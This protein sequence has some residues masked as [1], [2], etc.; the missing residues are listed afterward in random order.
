[1]TEPGATEGAPP[2][3]PWLLYLGLSAVVWGLFVPD[4]GLWHDDVQN[5]FRA[6]VAP[7]RGEGLLPAIATP[8]RR[9]LGLPFMAALATGYPVH[10]LHLFC[11]ASWLATGVLAD[12]L[13]RRLW[14][15]A[16][17]AAPLCAAL[18]LCATPDFFTGAPLAVAYQLSIVA[19]LGATLLGLAWLQGGSK[20]ALWTTPLCLSVS[21][22]T[23]DGALAAWPLTPLLWIAAPGTRGRR[24]VG[25]ALL[26]FVAPL[27]Y[28]VLV[29][30]QLTGG[31]YLQQALVP[32]GAGRWLGRCADLLLWNFTPWRWAL[33]RPLWFPSIGTVVPEPLRLAIALAAGAIAALLLLRR[34]PARDGARERIGLAGVAAS[35]GL[36]AVTSVAFASVQLSEVY[37]RT[38]LLARVFACLALGRLAAAAWGRATGTAGRALVRVALGGWLALGVAGALERQ[39]YFV[40]YTRAHRQELASWLGEAPALAPGAHLLLRVPEHRRYLA[41]EAGYLARAWAVLLYE[42]PSVECRVFLW[43]SN[44][45]TTCRPAADGFECSGERSPDCR[46]LDGRDTQLLPYDRLVLLQYEPARNAFVLSR[47]LPAEAAAG[48]LAYR[49]DAHLLARPRTPLAR[50]LLDAVGG[51]AAWLWP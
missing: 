27:P 24:R 3:T 40:G 18:V 13:A 41:T 9:L 43:S 50:A 46:R 38:H 6:Y 20:V 1:M 31:G 29:L 14:P 39:D 26:W 45:Q 51:P 2:S 32:L 17:L 47:E 44:R 22:W 8:T 49:P 34:G 28:L 48:A 10:A 12:R 11:A 15:D 37:C 35:L 5:L 33:D 23:S 7:E 4:Q 19:Y 16:P 21:L 25:L 30:R 36:M 42:D